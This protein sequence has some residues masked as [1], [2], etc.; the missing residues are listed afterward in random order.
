MTKVP[1]VGN[2]YRVTNASDLEPNIQY[3]KNIDMDEKGYLKLSAPFPRLTSTADIADF[4]VLTDAIQ[5]GTSDNDFKLATDSKIYD[6][7]LDDLSVTLDASA[8]TGHIA[9]RFV[10]WKGGDW[11]YGAPGDIYSL[12]SNT[13]TTWDIENNDPGDYIEIFVNKNSLV[14]GSL[15]RVDQYLTTDMDGGTPPSAGSGE[16][17]IIPGNFTITGQAYSNYR[18]GIGTY[19]E[20]KKQAF[21]FTWDGATAEAGQGTPVFAIQIIDVVAYQNSWAV[22]TSKG[23]LLRFNGAGFDKLGNLP[24]F[25]FNTNWI[26]GTGNT[27]VSH[28]R[29]MTV[30]G[31]II[32]INLGTLLDACEDDS[33]ILQGFYSGVWCY[34]DETQNLYHRY[35]LS[36]SKIH[37]ESLAPSSN[38][39]TS[40]SH[41]L[42][43]GD[44]VLDGN[45]TFYAIR[46]TDDTFSLASNYDD[47]IS[48]T[49]T[50]AAADGM[51]IWIKREDWTQLTAN[52]NNFGACIKFDAGGNLIGEGVVPFFVGLELTTK[53]MVANHTTCIM[54]PKF[55]NIGTICYYKM[56]AEEIEDKYRSII[57][58][59]RKLRD[60]DKIV[61]KY[62]TRDNY[63]PIAIGTAG[64]SSPSSFITWVDST[65]FTTT[66]DLTEVREGHEVEFF[67]GAGGGST[68]HIVSKTN[69]AGTW[70]VVVDEA[71]RGA[72][73]GNKSTCVFD[74]FIKLSTI[75]KDG[76]EPTCQYKA[77]LDEVSKWI[78]VKLELRGRGVSIEEMIV[79]NVVHKPI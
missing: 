21:F 20:G 23:Q 7:D 2:N 28:G 18:M 63:T 70:T 34:D 59:H 4:Q 74:S 32:Y 24:N 76:Q 66:E 36:N 11:Y 77:P 69:D 73:S 62:K 17:L 57:V 78:Q 15:G 29:M 65:S 19:D 12:Q 9:G 30:D 10:G 37:R 71:I 72:T 39:Y 1:A 5:I 44:K 46:L 25:Y 50:S 47:A 6:I 68:A 41:L 27:E 43:T 79:D 67:S 56:K 60:G 49:V 40:A 14:S 42:V 61:I 13:G 26:S 64:D 35:G 33:G 55:D 54:A 45:I 8:P 3:T 52:N 53:G 51:K 31:D 38:I 58:K 75:T 16:T 48:G 22:L